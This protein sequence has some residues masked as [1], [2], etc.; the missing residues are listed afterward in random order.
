M[1]GKR[2]VLAPAALTL[3]LVASACGGRGNAA[4]SGGDANAS[5]ASRNDAQLKFARCMR[6]HGIDIEDPKPGS[7]GGVRLAIRGKL[8]DEKKLEKAQKE[9]Q[10]LAPGGFREPTPEEAEKFKDAALAFARC[11]RAHGVDMPDPQ[12]D[13]GRTKIMIRGDRGNEKKVQAAQKAC[14]KLMPGPPTEKEGS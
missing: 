13:G 10:K 5:D 6:D 1:R 7:G 9:C 4:S 14:E 11:M 12:V 3:V 8:G 2:A